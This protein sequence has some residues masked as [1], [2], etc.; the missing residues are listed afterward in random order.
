MSWRG[1]LTD[2]HYSWTSLLGSLLVLSAHSFASN[3]QLPFLKQWKGENGR[4]NYFMT[5]LYERMLPDMWIG[6]RERPHTGRGRASDRPT[7]PGLEIGE[8]VIL[9]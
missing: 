7:A 9:C 2:P 5:N 8:Q 3:L 4:K 1:Q 6:P